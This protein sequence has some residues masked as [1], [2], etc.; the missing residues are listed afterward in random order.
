MNPTTDVSDGLKRQISDDE[1]QKLPL[2]DFV[3]PDNRAFF[4]AEPQDVDN[5]VQSFGRGDVSYAKFKARLIEIAKRKGA[6]FVAQL[7]QE[8][9]DDMKKALTEELSIVEQALKAGRVLSGANAQKIGN[10]VQSL[11][12]V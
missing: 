6:A 1:R 11:I 10:A 7:P 8:W 4:I 9:K 5:A 12:D 3:D 2:S